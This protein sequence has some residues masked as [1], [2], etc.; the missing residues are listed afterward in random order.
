MHKK[1][2]KFLTG[3]FFILI[4]SNAS[5]VSADC[6]LQKGSEE[7]GILGGYGKNFHTG[8]KGG[9]TRDDVQFFFFIPYWGKVIKEWDGCRNLEFLAEGFLDYSIQE[10]RD[11]YAAGI[12]PFLQYNFKNIGNATPFFGLGA[13][14]IYTDLDPKGFG[15]RF[16]FTPQMGIGIRYKINPDRHLIF[17]YRFHHISN[18]SISKENKSIDS[19]FF[20]I[21]IS[22][23]I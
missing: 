20:L 17:S 23:K 12:T 19:N 11:R 4:I 22:V 8:L 7:T 3:I 16:N 13:G 6:T 2:K 15:S 21:G 1:I 10:S 14:I 9:N 5:Y 18:S